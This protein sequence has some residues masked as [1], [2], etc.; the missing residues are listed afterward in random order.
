MRVQ[1]NTVLTICGGGSNQVVVQSD[2]R[3]AFNLGCLWKW[4][5]GFSDINWCNGGCGCACFS[6]NWFWLRNDW[7][8][9]FW[10]DNLNVNDLCWFWF[11][12]WL[13]LLFDDFSDLCDGG[14]SNLWF[15]GLLW[16]LLWF[17]FWLF[18]LLDNFDDLCDSRFSNLWFLRLLWLLLWLWFWLFFLLDNFSDLLDNDFGG[19]WF[20]RLLWLLLWLWFWLWLLFDDFG[21]LVNDDLGGLWFLRLLWLLLWLWFWSDWDYDHDSFFAGSSCLSLSGLGNSPDGFDVSSDS[22][23]LLG[24]SLAGPDA[25]LLQS[26]CCSL[27]PLSVSLVSVV[28]RVI[29][30]C[31]SLALP[32]CCD[33]RL[34][35]CLPFLYY[36]DS[37]LD[38]RRPFLDK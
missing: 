15:L 31:Y 37:L 29:S 34:S 35:C 36:G 1:P 12:L 4:L 8:W 6:R 17:R 21:D 27:Q 24:D 16:L 7:C 32:S 14:F 26:S 5:D 20:L 38:S 19:L 25:S 9:W 18:F 3:S 2:E 10:S 33:Y 28:V 23:E 13:W 11:W 30:C 22:G